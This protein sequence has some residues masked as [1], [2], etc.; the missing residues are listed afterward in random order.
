[1]KRYGQGLLLLTFLS[2]T[3]CGVKPGTVEPP[4]GYEDVQFPRTYPDPRYDPAP[5][6]ENK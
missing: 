3:A 6:L 4:E 5:G 2:L 1:M